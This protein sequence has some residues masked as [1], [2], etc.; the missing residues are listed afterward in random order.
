MNLPAIV[1]Q[2]PDDPLASISDPL[3]LYDAFKTQKLSL[4]DRL[5]GKS[6]ETEILDFKLKGSPS[7]DDLKKQRS[8]T[9]RSSTDTAESTAAT[10]QQAD[11]LTESDKENIVKAI[12]GFANTN[13]GILVW[14]LDCPGDSSSV[15][16][17]VPVENPSKF[18]ADIRDSLHHFTDPPVTVQCFIIH[19]NS[20]IP[21]EVAQSEHNS[22]AN[23]KP[24]YVIMYVPKSERI[25][26][27][28][29]LAGEINKECYRRIGSSFIRIPW[30][31]IPITRTQSEINKQDTDTRKRGG[32]L[33]LVLPW[34]LPPDDA[35]IKRMVHAAVKSRFINAY[36]RWTE[37]MPQLFP[38]LIRRQDAI[39]DPFGAFIDVDGSV[40]LTNSSV[41]NVF[42]NGNHNSAYRMLI[43]GDQGSGKTI[44]L[45]QIGKCLHDQFTNKDTSVLPVF[46]RLS[47]WTKKAGQFTNWITNEIRIMYGVREDISKRWLRQGKIVLL[48]DGLDE[49]P[50]SVRSDCISVMNEFLEDLT[51]CVPVI[52]TSRTEP[53]QQTGIRLKVNEAISLCA[54]TV[55]QI[56]SALQELPGSANWLSAV[57]ENNE[58]LGFLSSPLQIKL[59]SDLAR[60][61]P[62]DVTACVFEHQ[63]G[64]DLLDSYIKR[65]LEG[66][67]AMSTNPKQLLARYKPPFNSLTT[68]RRMS[69]LARRMLD[70]NT[71]ELQVEQL[72]PG[73]LSVVWSVV[74]IAPFAVAPILLLDFTNPGTAALFVLGSAVLS[75]SIKPVET[76]GINFAAIKEYFVGLLNPARAIRKHLPWL[77][78]PTKTWQW[79]VFSILIPV[80]FILIF[81]WV[82]GYIG[83]WLLRPIFLIP[84]WLRGGGKKQNAPK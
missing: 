43:L 55:D 8:K 60:K 53:Y 31:E 13:G 18:A 73:M 79:I 28:N 81:Y 70:G 58:L 12:S 44:C 39:D 67:F 62:D 19:E 27:I 84:I 76:I 41:L 47:S 83:L 54:L 57:A 72:E 15:V 10:Y 25:I 42:Q 35:T 6:Q 34:T 64:K 68:S 69:W 59:F 38:A 36:D 78:V 7:K 5:V 26:R 22:S 50:G 14:G 2:S 29:N 56:L 65:L 33:S 51:F 80:N 48:L 63:S 9:N 66:S 75:C 11:Y 82:C 17:K 4:I 40:A 45:L 16:R 49:V 21:S 32:I 3:A 74:Y 24:G 37:G 71:P 46:L 20:N 30:S 77:W 1:T 23:Q 52:I 61:H